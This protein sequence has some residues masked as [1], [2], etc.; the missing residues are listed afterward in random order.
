MLAR[1]LREMPQG[2]RLA[3]A[4]RCKDVWRVASDPA[5][6]TDVHVYDLSAAA[7]SVLASKYACQ[8]LTLHGRGGGGGGCDA[9]EAARFVQRHAP[10][11][12]AALRHLAIRIAAPGRASASAVPRWALAG[13]ASALPQLRSLKLWF[14]APCRTSRTS[15]IEF[16]CCSMPSL[17]K[18]VVWDAGRVARL[19]VRLGEG[20]EERLPRLR[21]LRLRAEASDALDRVPAM[22]RLTSLNYDVRLDSYDDF[23]LPPE[24]RMRSVWLHVR[25]STNAPA[26]MRQLA[27]VA[28][29]RALHVTVHED[30]RF[31]RSLPAH[32]LVLL[33]ADARAVVELDAAFLYGSGNLRTVRVQPSTWLGPTADSDFTLALTGLTPAQFRALPL[34]LDLC[35]G[36]DLHVTD[37]P[38]YVL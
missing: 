19:R 9:D 16:T 20:I 30:V 37:R 24:R 27:R 28:D 35:C 11:L 36:T 21:T 10:L 15:D 26:V 14:H 5:L 1:V 23:C 32:T 13:A 25:A 8:R 17:T 6:W 33:M 34:E 2:E 38:R 3:W 7:A 29:L 22:R 12:P 4:M 18:L 31:Q